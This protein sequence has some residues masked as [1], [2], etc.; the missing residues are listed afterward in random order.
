[1]A[2]V[3]MKFRIVA[4]IPD[5]VVAE[6]RR[7]QPGIFEEEDSYAFDIA[8]EAIQDALKANPQAIVFFKPLSDGSELV[9]DGSPEL[10]FEQLERRYD[11]ED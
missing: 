9:T 8:I 3:S 4:T 5:D 2:Q 11:Y 6:Y 1:M 10:D 7:Q